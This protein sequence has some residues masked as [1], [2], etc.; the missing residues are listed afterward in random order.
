[1]S[2]YDRDR[3]TLDRRRLDIHQE[4]RLLRL[5][6]E[7]GANRFYREKLAASGVETAAVRT[8]GDLGGLPFTSKQELVEAQLRRPPYGDLLTYPLSRYR[9]MHQ[10]SGTTGKPLFWLDGEEGWQTWLRSWGQVYRGAGV[11]EDDVVFCAFSFGPFVAHWAALAGARAIGALAMPGSGLSSLQRLERILEH[12]ATAVVSTPTY[13]L[14]LAEVA[15]ANGLDLAA[16]DVRVTIH[17]GEPGAS[18][19]GVK[20]AI[21]K[22]WGARTFDHAGATEI[23]AWG[24]D[25]LTEDTDLH[26]N[27]LEFIFEVVDPETGAP[28]PD[29]DRGELVVTNLGR[30]E[31]PVVRYRTRDLVIRTSEPCSCGRHMARLIGGVLGRADDMLVVRGVN[32]FPSAVDNLIR[33]IPAIVEYEVEVRTVAAMSELT[34]KVETAPG[35]LFDDVESELSKTFLSRLAIRVDIEHAD[36][37]SL[38][39]YELKARRFKRLPA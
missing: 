15:A 25:C 37:G 20:R 31:M 21:E 18:V 6:E 27:E 12:R 4:E 35:A 32:V 39:R 11:G 34:V 10:T 36:A 23:G 1:M 28:V 22:A 7:I 14:H 8:L 3:E 29:G 13:A 9:Y 38:P 24:F 33:E 5:L 19:P 17:A 26:L 30:P 2:F 16:S